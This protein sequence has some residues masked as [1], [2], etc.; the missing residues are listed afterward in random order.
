MLQLRDIWAHVN[1]GRE[2]FDA[3][4]EDRRTAGTANAS[5]VPVAATPHPC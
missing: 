5:P 3:W 4:T 2:I 1:C